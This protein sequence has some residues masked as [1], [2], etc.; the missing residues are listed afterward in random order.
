MQYGLLLNEDSC[1]IV[2]SFQYYNDQITS[3]PEFYLTKSQLWDGSFRTGDKVCCSIG[4]LSLSLTVGTW[5]RWS[6]TIK[7]LYKC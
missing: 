7:G 4:A 1:A 6:I 2:L 5:G 3:L